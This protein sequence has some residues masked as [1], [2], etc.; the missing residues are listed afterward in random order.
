MKA[1]LITI[2]NEI[3]LGKT[4]NSNMAFL[5]SE[6]AKLGIPVEYAVTIK[7]DPEAIIKALSETWDRFDVVIS[8]GGLGPTEDDLSKSAIARFFGVQQHFE[9]EVWTLVQKLFAQRGMPT[10]EINRC[11][12][13]VP[14][15]F[16]AL[17]NDRG[18]APGLHYQS[19]GKHFFALQ[20][21][22][23]EMRF[24]YENHIADI[25]K[26][27]Y[28][29]LRPIFQ[30]TLHTH[31]I[32]E[33]RLA[34]LFSLSDLPEKVSLAWLP[35]TGRVDMRFYGTSPEAIDKGIAAALKEINP[36]VWSNEDKSPA[37]VLTGL[38]LTNGNTIS[39]AESCTGGWVSKLI[40]DVAGASNI[41]SSGVIAY[42]NE[43]KVN[44]LKVDKNILEA[45]GA[46]SEE[47]ALA[48]AKGIKLLTGSS[49]AISTTGI[50]GPSGGTATKPVGL[51]CFGF[52]ADRMFWTKKQIFTGDRDSIRF[53]A[54]EFALLEIIRYM[55]GR[56][57]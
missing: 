44:T 21:V 36:Y 14:D 33:S 9:E 17:R 54:A 29:D 27:A 45:K 26:A 5:G 18:T 35:Q 37:E 55:Q 47:C 48:M 11:Q 3:L 51:V 25:L 6:L 20:G 43:I 42:A 4:L 34:E 40:T 2:G 46:V 19:E 57:N 30:K 53:K 7:D 31:G 12:A 39:V 16:E 49:F 38:M 24:I 1:A 28:P 22:P 23:L 13:M 50:A 15:G 56:N 41:F 52:I 32:S 10:P 8:T